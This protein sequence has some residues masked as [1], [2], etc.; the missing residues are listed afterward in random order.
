M[1]TQLLLNSRITICVY[2]CVFVIVRYLPT[3]TGCVFMNVE[4]L[5]LSVYN[6]YV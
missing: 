1:E 2:L 5:P 3:L 4:L 6:F